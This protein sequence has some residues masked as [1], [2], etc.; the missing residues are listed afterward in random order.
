MA[1]FISRRIVRGLITLIL[2]QGLIFTLI[3][4]IPYDFSTTQAGGGRAWREFIQSYFGLDLPLWE[5]YSRWIIRFFQFDLGNSFVAW[6]TPVSQVLLERMPRTLLLFFTA[7]ILAYSFGIWMGKMIAWHRGGIFEAS[8]TLG[9]VAAFTSFAPFL[10]FMA[11][12]IFGWYLGWFPYQ[13]LVSHVVWFN[14]PI[15]VD[16][17]LTRMVITGAL[18]FGVLF[19]VQRTTRNFKSRS[20]RW[21]WRLGV[22][23]VTILGTWIWW[24]QSGLSHLALD[25]LA[26]LVLPL[27]TVTLLSFGETMMLMRMAMLE[28]MQEDYVLTA[29]AKGL[30]DQEVRDRH[31]ARNA[32]LP[33]LTR[34]FLN[35]PFVLVGSLVI[36]MVFQW[37]GMGILIFNA[38]EN[39]DVPVLMGILSF[40]GVLTLCA[41]VVL[42]ILYVYLDPR[43]RYYRA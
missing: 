2:F 24:A 23:L 33:V 10:G 1:R 22:F 13:R 9:G 36:E 32:I 42:D 43:L 37:N 30:S 4:K 16:A 7:S 28:T 6:P 25:V 18:I 19:F 31:I 5:Q 26:H 3:H 20:Q 14:A 21:G 38:I 27:G 35:M 40:V 17:L 39:V 11:L 12:N 41:H 8:A 34:L 15:S 29:K